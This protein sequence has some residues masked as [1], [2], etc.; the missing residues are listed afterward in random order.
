VLGEVKLEEQASTDQPTTDGDSDSDARKPS[1]LV[2]LSVLELEA[3]MNDDAI[4][5]LVD[6]RTE[7][8]RA[9][10]TIDGF[11]LLDEAEHD[12]LTGLDVETPLVFLC[13][14]GIRSQQAAEYF[15]QRGFQNLYNV[16]GGI[17]AWSQFVDGTVP[18][19]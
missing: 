11:R 6:V 1:P 3:L 8:E 12:R 19:Y 9:I 14:H 17:D 5:E 15:R 4:R 10:A 16:Q 18:R 2:Q 7:G 13:H